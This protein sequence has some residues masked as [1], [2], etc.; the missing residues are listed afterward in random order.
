MPCTHQ[1]HLLPV[2]VLMCMHVLMQA[3]LG[4][5]KVSLKN[6]EWAGSSDL[7]IQLHSTPDTTLHTQLSVL[8][9][10][11]LSV[12]NTVALVGYAL[13][14]TT[15]D[16]LQGLP[17]CA[18]ALDLT[19]CTWPLQPPAPYSKL[20]QLVPGCY[21]K[22]LLGDRVPGEV[23]QELQAG[24]S[25]RGKEYTSTVQLVYGLL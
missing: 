3:S 17:K 5:Y 7:T 1:T 24:V 19:A 11:D 6:V 20:A 8:A 16:A 22:W 21:T 10:A 12:L 14:P 25:E 9:T 13:T 15:M 23:R 2:N 4:S 18:R